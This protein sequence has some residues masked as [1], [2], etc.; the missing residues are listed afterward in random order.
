LRNLAFHE[1]RTGVE[2]SY[3]RAGAWFPLLGNNKNRL[4]NLERV[5]FLTI[6][7]AIKLYNY[8]MNTE[9]LSYSSLESMDYIYINYL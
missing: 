4:P 3:Q 7:A 2:N 8:I 9:H 5:L 6:H 1:V